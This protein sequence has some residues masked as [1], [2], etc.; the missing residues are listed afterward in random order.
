MHSILQT[1]TNPA[2]SK[3]T[4]TYRQFGQPLALEPRVPCKREFIACVIFEGHLKKIEIFC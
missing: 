1:L 2:L 3:N 4:T